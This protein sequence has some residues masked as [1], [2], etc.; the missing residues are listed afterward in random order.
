MF[1]S[2]RGGVRFSGRWMGVVSSSFEPSCW[3]LWVVVLEEEGMVREECFRGFLVCGLVWLKTRMSGVMS[4]C[5]SHGP[6][7]TQEA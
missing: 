5:L 4:V 7:K 3:L 6:Q 1:W 2:R